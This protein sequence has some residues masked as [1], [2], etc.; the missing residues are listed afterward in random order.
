MNQP[1]DFNAAATHVK[2]NFLIG[3]YVSGEKAD[4]T[5]NK[6]DYFGGRFG[7]K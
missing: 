7:K 3:Y 6:G 1:F 4:P 5:W 2:V